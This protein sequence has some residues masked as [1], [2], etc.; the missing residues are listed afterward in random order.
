MSRLLLPGVGPGLADHLAARGPLQAVDAVWLADEVE[1]AGLTGR[2]GARF[3]LHRKLRAVAGARKP[4]VVANAAEGEPASRKDATLL[5][6]APHLVLDGLDLAARAVGAHRR[7]V[8]VHEGPGVAHVRRA[9]DERPGGEHVEVVD[10]PAAFLSGEESA[11]VS[12]VD[13]RPALPRTRPPAVWQQGVG[14]R[15]TLVSNAETLAHL[16]LLARHGAADFRAE[17]TREE[18]GTMLCTVSGAVRRG[19]VVEAAIGT[20]LAAVLSA[21]GGPAEP[22]RAVLVGGYHGAWLDAGLLETPLSSAG[23]APQGAS[24]GA[25]VLVALPASACPLRA[26]AVIVRYLADS[27]ARQCGPCLNGLPAL[28]DTLDR[29]ASA[30]P[31]GADRLRLE[32]LTG[33]VAGR[34]AC[35]HPDGTVRFVRSVLTTFADDLDAHRAGDCV[36]TTAIRRYASSAP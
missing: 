3:P 25:G 27:S 14:G 18:P 23:L 36:A 22:L 4:V 16:A 31:T 7:I 30:A 19:G 20:P 6:R 10:A 21:A 26:A 9:L 32:Q 5:E 12:R 17:G 11:L 35:H 29:L 1:R 24:P 2:G 33:L 34:G 15:A 8:S 28:A 13:G